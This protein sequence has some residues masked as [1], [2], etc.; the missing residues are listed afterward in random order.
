M[1]ECMIPK[2]ASATI[3]YICNKPF[4]IKIP[5][6]AVEPYISAIAGG[7]AGLVDPSDPPMFTQ[8]GESGQSLYRL[9]VKPGEIINVKLGRGQ[10]SGIGLTAENN[11]VISF[12]SC[13]DIITL[14]G[15]DRSSIPPPLIIT[16]R[17]PFIFFPNAPGGALFGGMDGTLIIEAV[18]FFPG[19]AGRSGGFVLQEDPPRAIVGGRGGGAGAFIGSRGGDGG[20]FPPSA[21]QSGVLG[22]GGGSGSVIAEIGESGPTSFIKSPSGNG[23][24]GAFYVEYYCFE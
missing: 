19:V 5:K 12:D 22:G 24:D 6:C 4:R 21:G 16:E 2:F 3:P 11:T 8:G 9:P 23:G 13:S 20:L 18:G 17:S 14:R 7:G 10:I 15:G 1:C